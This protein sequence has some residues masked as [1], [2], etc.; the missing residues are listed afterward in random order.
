MPQNT[1]AHLTVQETLPPGNSSADR[2]WAPRLRRARLSPPAWRVARRK[3]S[4]PALVH[5]V[6]GR[7]WLVQCTRL[8]P[9]PL[10]V[11]WFRCHGSFAFPQ[12]PSATASLI[13]TRLSW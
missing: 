9:C 4:E 10:G 6:I 3:G 8:A 12:A 1:S 11:D 2:G 7:S 5:D 13:S